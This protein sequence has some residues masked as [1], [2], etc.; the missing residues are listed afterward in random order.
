VAGGQTGARRE[1]RG[2]L[3]LAAGKAGWGRPVRPGW[4]RGIGCHFSFG[5][6]IAHVAEVSVEKEGAVRVRRVVSGVD[7]GPAVNPDG[8]RAMAEG[9]INF[10]LTPVLGGEISIKDGAVEQSNFHDYQVMLI[11]QSPAMEV[12]IVPSNEPPGGMGD[13]GVP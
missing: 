11:N 10:A 12:H 5:S 1:F 2:V 7:C 3:Q 13:P 8:V 4:G 9:A 6:Y